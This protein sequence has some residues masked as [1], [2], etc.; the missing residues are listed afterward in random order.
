MSDP[1]VT[2]IIP[3]YPNYAFL[4]RALAS[5]AQQGFGIGDYEVIVIDDGCDSDPDSIDNTYNLPLRII[6]SPFNRGALQTRILGITNAQGTYIQ[7]LDKDDELS[8]GVTQHYL[9]VA[10]T[11]NQPSMVSGVILYNGRTKRYTFDPE[12]IQ[13]KLGMHP[14]DYYYHVSWHCCNRIIRSDTARLAVTRLK[15]IGLTGSD[16]INIKDDMLLMLA[17][18]QCS[19]RMLVVNDPPNVYIYNRDNPESLYK[20]SNRMH[21]QKGRDSG[22]YDAYRVQHQRV[23]ELLA[24]YKKTFYCSKSDI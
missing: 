4:D 17:V 11:N 18:S 16:Y 20:A 22:L 14:L 10:A 7:F 3:V 8:P 23:A 24:A 13:G 2:F 6:K 1:K 12:L 19:D 9:D 21:T 15:E 5:V